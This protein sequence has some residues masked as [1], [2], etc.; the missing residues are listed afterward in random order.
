M[1]T[2]HDIQL[3][4]GARGK[5]RFSD[6][7]DEEREAY[8]RIHGSLKA[9]CDLVVRELARFG[10][11]A[12]KL[13][14][15][16]HVN[17]GIRGYLP[18]DLWFAV[19]PAANKDR[20]AA[21]PQLFL[22]VSERGLEYGYGAS[23]HPSDFSNPE[24]KDA[25]RAAAPKVFEKLPE[26]HS[27]EADELASNIAQSGTWYFCKKHRLVPGESDFKTLHDWLG[28]LHSP[29]GRMAAAGTISRYLRPDEVD[30]VDLEKELITAARLFAPLMFR[31]W[32]ASED[33]HLRQPRTSA[34][35]VTD[36]P[37]SSESS[38]FSELLR[39]FLDEYA[40]SRKGAFTLSEDLKGTIS[41]L[42][43]RLAAFPAVLKRPLIEVEVSVGKGGWTKTPWIALLNTAVTTTT[44]QGIYGVFLVAEDLSRVYLTLNQGMTELV[45]TNGQRGA[46]EEM[47]RVA[48]EVRP[49]V[50]ELA[51]AGFRLDNNINLRS[52]TKRS[53]NYEIGTIA[54]FEL[55]PELFPSDRD[56]EAKL[57]A[58]LLAYDKIV[59]GEIGIAGAEADDLSDPGDDG[60]MASP[61]FPAPPAYTVE[62]ALQ[63]LFLPKD[64]IEQLLTVWRHKKNL[65]L[66]GAPGVGKSFVSRR[67]AYALIGARDPSRVETVQFHQS[68]SYEDFVQGYRPSGS[69]GFKLQD[70]A[71]HRFRRTAL[72]NPGEPHVFIIDEINRGNLS[73]IFGELML[74]MESDKRSPEWGTQLAYAK[75]GEPKFYVPDNLFI[76]GMMNTADRSLS[77]VDY[78][79]RRRFAFATLEPMFRAEKFRGTLAERGVPEALIDAIVRRM[80]DLNEAIAGDR[81]NLGPGFQIGH[82]FFVP[83]AHVTYHDGWYQT[84]VETEIVPLLEEYWFDD[85]SKADGWRERLL[86]PTS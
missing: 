85:P 33:E 17:S 44:Q 38:S 7:T 27:V 18:K 61:V 84:I 13:T 10:N 48:A 66:Q 72:G 76:L 22:I 62:D 52:D 36:Q 77:M 67:L 8:G 51:D 12:Q 24:A 32:G 80:S 4:R 60:A 58:L 15:G 19:Y 54:H 82:S 68:Y 73:K 1:I 21:N 40:R 31:D 9:L 81:A 79:L 57:E 20:L 49:K 39:A 35:E 34:A 71:F 29:A 86:A 11:A 64:K 30:Q 2:R 74:L 28:Y 70:G 83:Q 69:G 42:K 14:S 16:F 50:P 56:L 3:L 45:L 63:D 26:P 46:T 78:A 37:I 43:A 5:Q 59:E 6:L 25:V 41:S 47:L 75:P 55:R 65:I 23:V 53:Q